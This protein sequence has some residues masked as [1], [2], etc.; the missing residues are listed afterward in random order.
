[1]DP[2]GRRHR[3]FGSICP[4]DP[5]VR[6]ANLAHAARTATESGIRGILIDG[7]RF[8]SPASGQGV[9][10][11]FTCFC[12]RCRRLAG[13]LGLDPE[14]MAAGADWA[15]RLCARESLPQPGDLGAALA[16]WRAFRQA[17]VTQHIRGF[18]RTVK[19]VNPALDVGIYSFTPALAPWVGQDYAA[20]ADAGIQWFSPMI[21]RCWPEADGPACLNI[22]LAALA[23]AL[24]ASLDWRRARE[25]LEEACQVEIPGDSPAAL[26]KQGFA[27]A[28]IAAETAR[29]RRAVGA[30][31][32][33][34]IL[35]LQD[36]QLADAESEALA[37][38]AD[39]VALFSWNQ[40]SPRWLEQLPR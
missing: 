40:E 19:A 30:L 20:L 1:M 2:Q 36:P 26:R 34:P 17:L 14:R 33:W 11:F 21:Y 22:E 25:L 15:Q 35:Q 6:A 7:C 27:P 10:S 12:P 9:N 32:V 38:G 31:P 8:S 39:G 23:E 4:S 5:Q 28:I 3:W 24:C 18:V 29:V 16:Q 37:G 13:E